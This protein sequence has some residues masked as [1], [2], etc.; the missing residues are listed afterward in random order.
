MKKQE[1][2]A[3]NVINKAVSVLKSG[4]VIIFPTDTVFGIGCLASNERA[5]ERIKQIKSSSQNFPILLSDIGQVESVGI[6]NPVAEQL[7]KKYWP[8]GLT[9]IIQNNKGG[10]VGVRIPQ[11]ELILSVIDTIG[12]PIVGTSANFHGDPAPTTY[13]EINPKLSE[14]VDLAI[15]GECKNN[16]ESTV[17]DSTVNPPKI[18]RQGAVKI[19]ETIN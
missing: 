16:K 7:A 4:G 11:S 13:K 1:K 19:N 15:E 3:S 5:V 8:G 18:L 17:V 9:L 6:M 12:E 14:L 2:S 10:T